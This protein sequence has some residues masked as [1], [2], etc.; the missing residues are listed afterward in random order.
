MNCECCEQDFLISYGSGRFC[1][2]SCARRYSTKNKRTE[3][4]KKVSSTLIGRPSEKKGVPISQEHKIKVSEALKGKARPERRYPLDK[5]L[6]ENST[7]LSTSK[8][9][10]RLL[11]ENLIDY[12]CSKCGNLGVHCGEPLSLQL[13]HKNGVNNDNRLENLRLLCPNCHSQTPTYA[14]KNKKKLSD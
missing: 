3:I 9:K 14:G 7:F 12:V 8:I 4:N 13:D 11:D 10:K 1:S 5:M 2:S 6:I